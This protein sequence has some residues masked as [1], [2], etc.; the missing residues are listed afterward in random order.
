MTDAT[1]LVAT[2]ASTD[3]DATTGQCT[4]IVWVQQQ[5]VGLPPLTA[6]QGAEISGAIA[7]LW[8]MGFLVRIIR[9]AMG[10]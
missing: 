3:V 4:N 8:S 6:A 7:V 1:Q 2:C 10:V 5:V 9:K